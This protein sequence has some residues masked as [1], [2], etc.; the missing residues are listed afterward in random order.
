MYQESVA[1]D[2]HDGTSCVE[3]VVR[4][5]ARSE[6]C[7]MKIWF[8]RGPRASDGSSELMLGAKSREFIS[9]RVE[10]EEF[11]MNGFGSPSCSAGSLESN[12]NGVKRQEEFETVVEDETHR[13]E[14][15]DESRP[16]IVEIDEFEERARKWCMEYLDKFTPSLREPPGL[17]IEREES[18]A[19]RKRKIP[20]VKIPKPPPPKPAPPGVFGPPQQ[21]PLQAKVLPPPPPW[22]KPPDTG[23]KLC[24]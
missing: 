1:K 9:T 20:N 16:G 13:S 14:A 21:D 18:E 6:D 10:P 8:S 19:D 11:R 17:E 2:Q 5:I 22:Q 3:S 23:S 7:P 24:E 12:W 4:E 15:S